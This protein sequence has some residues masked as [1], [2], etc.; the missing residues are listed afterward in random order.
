MSYY[1]A[2]RRDTNDIDNRRSRGKLNIIL[3]LFLVILMIC[4]AFEVSPYMGF[5]MV[6]TL[7][8]L[9]HIR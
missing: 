7:I 4:A 5:A 1:S 6:G 3:N 8:L 2:Y 9:S